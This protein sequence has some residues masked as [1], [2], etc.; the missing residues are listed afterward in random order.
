MTFKPGISGNPSGKPPGTQSKR[1]Q[2]AKLLE[3]HAPALINKC[4][5]L[6]LDG[7]ESCLRL[8]IERIIPRAKNEPANISLPVGKIQPESLPEMGENILRQLESGDITLE[9]A[10][11]LLNILKSYVTITPEENAKA[12]SLIETFVNKGLL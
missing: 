12:L 6:A 10:Q 2:L 9:Q 5:E 8:A 7:N 3:P 1:T 11:A 4:V